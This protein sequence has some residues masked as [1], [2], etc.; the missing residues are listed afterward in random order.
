MDPD[1]AGAITVVITH[2]VKAGEFGAAHVRPAFEITGSAGAGLEADDL[3][4]RRQR[5][6]PFTAA[7]KANVNDHGIGTLF[8]RA[9]G[10]PAFGVERHAG[11][12]P[13]RRSW[14]GLHSLIG[15][16]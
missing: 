11:K 16:D 9:K 14:S 1:P 7:L 4:R 6:V 12:R 3:A 2:E 10:T 5:I 8:F 15:R 13:I